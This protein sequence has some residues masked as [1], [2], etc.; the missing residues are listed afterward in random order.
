MRATFPLQA[1]QEAVLARAYRR[2]LTLLPPLAAAGQAEALFLR[3]YLA[4]RDRRASHADAEA[5]LQAAA[6]QNHGEALYVLACRVETSD[7][8]TFEP[9]TD[10]TG[11]DHLHRAAEAGS[12]AAQADLAQHYA[13]GVPGLAADPAAARHWYRQLLMRPDADPAAL[14]PSVAYDLGRALLD[15]LGEEDDVQVGT[16]LIGI[17]AREGER[18]NHPVALEAAL[19]VTRVFEQGLYGVPTDP[20]LARQVWRDL[21]PRRGRRKQPP[22]WEDFILRYVGHALRYDLRGAAFEQVVAFLFAH[23]ARSRGRQ[24]WPRA[25]TVLF[26]P[27]ELVSHYTRL[28][29]DPAF[30]FER[31]GRDELTQGFR[32]LQSNHDWTVAALVWN[33]AVPLAQRESCI[34]AMVTLFEQVFAVDALGE[35]SFHWWQALSQPHQHEARS[36]FF[37]DKPVTR[38]SEE[39]WTRTRDA[40]FAALEQILYLDALNCKL[41]ALNGLIHLHHPDTEPLIRAFLHV[42]SGDGRL[43][44][45]AQAALNNRLR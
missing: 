27:G 31:F 29:T 19:F 30:L 17:A 8:Y 24:L 10:P 23:P 43:R 9:P 21:R 15:H 14:R 42:T 36:S 6:E 25:A 44:E 13:V 20:E 28:F 5:W 7:G 40:M 12:L 38:L 33:S 2:A 45:L 18:I 26:H 34:G 41:A 35:T 3:G 16:Q 4:F 1:A 39:E 32:V 11:W 22:T 37:G